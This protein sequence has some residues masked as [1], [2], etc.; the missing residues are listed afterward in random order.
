MASQQWRSQDI[1]DTRA[2]HGIID[3][4]GMGTVTTFARNSAPSA[5][6]IGRSGACSPRILQPPKSVL[7]PYRS[8][9]YVT[10][11]SKFAYG[12]LT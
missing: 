8:A 6:V 9:V 2:Q 1:A 12:E 11:Y 7:R 4:D 5:E 3:N 10:F